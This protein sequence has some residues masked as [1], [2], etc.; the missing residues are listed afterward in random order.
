MENCSCCSP[1]TEFI[2]LV[3]AASSPE[4]VVLEFCQVVPGASQQQ[5]VAES[6]LAARFAFTWQRIE[7][8]HG[9][10]GAILRDREKGGS[11]QQAPVLS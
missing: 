9:L 11:G 1:R 10:F 6:R 7:R 5:G 8:L 4:I 3:R 2:D